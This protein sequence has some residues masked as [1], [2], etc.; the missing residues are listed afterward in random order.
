M[1][2]SVVLLEAMLDFPDTYLVYP[3]K[4]VNTTNYVTFI[5][6]E[7]KED[8]LRVTKVWQPGESRRE[9]RAIYEYLEN[10]SKEE[11]FK[12]VKKIERS[13]KGIIKFNL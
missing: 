11:R 4:E 10:L 6:Y 3:P 7:D 2:G 8:Y 13:S 9:V 1:I 5:P 12:I